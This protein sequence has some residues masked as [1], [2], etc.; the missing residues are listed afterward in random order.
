M[1]L[2]YAASHSHTSL[3]IFVCS[4]ASILDS[5]IAK[6]AEIFQ[7]VEDN[8]NLDLQSELYD[9]CKARHFTA[10]SKRL[11]KIFGGQ[12]Q[13]GHIKLL[14]CSRFSSQPMSVRNRL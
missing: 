5:V 11:A 12:E 2:S 6:P 4:L 9:V 10:Y 8:T 7:D 3:I 14:I 13:L 1:D